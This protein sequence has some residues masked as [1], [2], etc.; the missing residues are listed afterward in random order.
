MRYK[1][2]ALRHVGSCRQAAGGQ[3]QRGLQTWALSRV[4]QD[5]IASWPKLAQNTGLESKTAHVYVVVLE[6][7]FLGRNLE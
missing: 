1:R 7:Y 5:E 2:R 6:S 3:R 4:T